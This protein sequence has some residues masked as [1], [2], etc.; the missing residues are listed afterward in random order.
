MHKG[1]RFI[2]RFEISTELCEGFILLFNDRNPLHTEDAFAC[3]KGFVKKV[4]H[5]NI[6][7]GFLSFFVGECL[8]DKNVMIYSQKIDFK[9]PVYAGDSLELHAVID[10]IF[11]SV[12]LAE[13]SF[14]FINQDSVKVAKGKIQIG[15]LK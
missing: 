4:M 7:N 15:L 5:G 10:D 11:E 13:I 2:Q 9:K 14:E 8:P 3:E 12:N 6:L 1:D